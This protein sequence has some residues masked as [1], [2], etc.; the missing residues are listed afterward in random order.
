MMLGSAPIFFGMDVS[1]SLS[2]EPTLSRYCLLSVWNLLIRD[3]IFFEVSAADI[4]S[5]AASTS[6]DMSEIC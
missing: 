5:V 2:S 6:S 4:G 1:F 3:N